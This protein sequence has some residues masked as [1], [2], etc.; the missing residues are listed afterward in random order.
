MPALIGRAGSGRKLLR[1][2]SIPLLDALERHASVCKRSSMCFYRPLAGSR[3]KAQWFWGMKSRGLM[4]KS[5]RIT[6]VKIVATDTGLA[7]IS[8]SL[9][10]FESFE[11]QPSALETCFGQ[12]ENHCE[13]CVRKTQSELKDI[14]ECRT[15][16]CS[17]APRMKRSHRSNQV[18]GPTCS[19]SYSKPNTFSPR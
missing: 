12:T 16:R 10:G 18:S 19:T 14:R 5:S 3:T 4:N 6:H 13:F 1:G 11:K 7:I 8:D 2:R 17:E 9:R 15:K